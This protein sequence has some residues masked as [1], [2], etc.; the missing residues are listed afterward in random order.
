VLIVLPTPV[1]LVEEPLR[2]VSLPLVEY[3]DP[4][5]VEEPVPVPD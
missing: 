4:V 1:W 5:A 2:C 3:P